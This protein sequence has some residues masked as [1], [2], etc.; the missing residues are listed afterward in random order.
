MPKMTQFE[1]E[2]AIASAAPAA[3]EA[4]SVTK[5]AASLAAYIQAKVEAEKNDAWEKGNQEWGNSVFRPSE[6][7]AGDA[8]AVYAKTDAATLAH[9]A[10]IAEKLKKSVGTVQAVFGAV[11]A[12]GTAYMTGGIA[13][14][15]LA[16]SL[17]GVAADVL[18][19]LGDAS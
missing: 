19:A 3:G 11:T 10:A 12:L 8:G 13:L 7:T 14:P 6:I 17:Q 15:A 4:W 5:V 9:R 18:S 2:L 16:S 1:I